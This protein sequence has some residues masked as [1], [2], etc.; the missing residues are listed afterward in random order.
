MTTRQFRDPQG[1][2]IAI[3]EVPTNVGDPDDP[4]APCNAPLHDP[5]SNLDHLYFHS[6]FDPMEVAFGPINVVV[7]HAAIPA[8]SG[9][10]GVG[11]F[12]NTMVYGSIVRSHE[13]FSHDL[14]YPPD[15]FLIIGDDVVHPGFPVQYD[16]ADGRARLVTAYATDNKIMLHE[17]G[18][19]T[20]SA[21]AATNVTYTLLIL[22]RPPAPA[23]SVLFDFDPS[24]GIVEMAFGKFRSDRR[25]LQI[26]SGGTPFGVPLGRTIGFDNGTF[27]SASPSGAL[28]DIVPADFRVSFGSGGPSYGPAGNYGGAFTGDGAV[29]VQAP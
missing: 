9:G 22:R 17:F 2:R 6:D 25:Y 16:L 20:S 24:T 3:Y 23:G 7:G 26:V 21:L 13:L 8:G 18:I 1:R 14:G 19:Q 10:G 4:M 27:R 29:L 28:R 5:D 12:T 11:S 15:F